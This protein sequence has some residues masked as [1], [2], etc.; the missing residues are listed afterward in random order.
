VVERHIDNARA[1][2]A[3]EDVR[4]VIERCAA[5]ARLTVLDT[6]FAGDESMRF[7]ERGGGRDAND[8]M[9]WAVIRFNRHVVYLRIANEADLAG[10]LTQRF[11][12]A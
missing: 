4:A 3:V 1:V 11:C 2:E 6:G 10:R 7:V 8:H 12:Q 5:Y 9:Y